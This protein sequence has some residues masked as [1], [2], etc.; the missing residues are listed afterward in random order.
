[1]KKKKKRKEKGANR[2]SRLLSNA[3]VQVGPGGPEEGG[4]G[5]EKKK[6]FGKKKKK[7]KGKKGGKEPGRGKVYEVQ[8]FYYSL[9]V[10]GR[11]VCPPGS[12]RRE[13]KREK[14]KEKEKTRLLRI[15]HFLIR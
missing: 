12:R 4:K 13:K 15:S 1:V 3:V 5:R 9:L 7:G 10:E 8:L 14:V 6:G 11:R 2:H